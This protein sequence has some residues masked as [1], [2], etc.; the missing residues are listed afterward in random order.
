MIWARYVVVVFPIEDEASMGRDSK[1][2]MNFSYPA[3][4]LLWAVRSEREKIDH[5][6]T[7]F[8]THL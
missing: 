7:P 2:K 3:T 4:A 8:S 6:I 5:G 1:G